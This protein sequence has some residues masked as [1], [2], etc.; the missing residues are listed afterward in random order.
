VD[1]KHNVKDEGGREQELSL[2][3]SSCLGNWRSLE[4]KP[5][6]EATRATTESP[7][8][9][10]EP[11]ALCLSV[12]SGPFQNREWPTLNDLFSAIVFRRLDVLGRRDHQLSELQFAD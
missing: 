4:A 1:G 3:V 11:G 10:E 9:L 2:L 6:K 7:G 12:T 5:P 8:I